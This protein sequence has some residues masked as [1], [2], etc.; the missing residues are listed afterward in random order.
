MATATQRVFLRGVPVD[1]VEGDMLV[2]KWNSWLSYFLG[3]FNDD[4]SH[5]TNVTVFDG[6]LVCVSPCPFDFTDQNGHVWRAGIDPRPIELLADP[7]CLKLWLVRGPEARRPEMN[8]ATRL[9][10]AQQIDENKRRG[11]LYESGVKEFVATLFGWAQATTTKFH[12]AEFS[13][14]LRRASGLWPR[15]ETV[16][17]TV[18]HLVKTVGG[19]CT[20][21]F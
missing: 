16:S 18:P 9:L 8:V 2:T 1:V 10:C 6:R 4:M 20:R 11:S 17:C 15:N 21:I 14:C 5:V 19:T 3:A 12:C 13:A 7:A